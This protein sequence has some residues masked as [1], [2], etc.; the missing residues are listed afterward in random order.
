LGNQDYYALANDHVLIFCKVYKVNKKCQ[1]NKTVAA[2]PVMKNTVR[3]NNS[4]CE[5]MVWILCY[6]LLKI[7]S[8][9][10]TEGSNRF[11]FCSKHPT[12]CLVC[13]VQQPR[14]PV[15]DATAFR[16]VIIMAWIKAIPIWKRCLT[17]V[18]K[19]DINNVEGTN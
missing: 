6:L 1:V 5:N 9:L 3:K 2:R 16:H 7:P 13:S 17:A 14:Q 10:I 18:C 8:K 12:Y 15:N 19:G 11:S 4:S